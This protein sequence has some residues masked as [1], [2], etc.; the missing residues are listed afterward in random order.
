MAASKSLPSLLEESNEPVLVPSLL[1]V[2][3]VLNLKTLIPAKA[4]NLQDIF[5]YK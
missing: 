2:P 1:H 5:L 4:G 3:R